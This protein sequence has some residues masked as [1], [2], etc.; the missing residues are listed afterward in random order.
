MRLILTTILLIVFTGCSNSQVLKTD[1]TGDVLK[2]LKILLPDNEV[3]VDIID[4]VKMDPRYELLYSKFLSAVKKNNEWFLQQQKT[5]EQTGNPMPY[6]PNVGMSESEY[7]EFKTLIEKGPG[8]EM[9]KSGSAKV[10]FDY[11]SDIIRL[12]GT[13]RLEILNDVKIDLENN[14]VW[15]GDFKL[16]DFQEINVDTDNNGLKSKWKGYQW[17]YEYTNKP[18]GFSELESP[19]DFQDLVMKQYKLTVGRLDKDLTTY[20]EITEKEIENGVKTKTIQ[21]PFKF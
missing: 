8:V 9:G 15:I 13:D 18:N 4:G 17:R 21:I 5:V 6:H 2:D 3:K 10:A 14:I 19:E 1:L 12:K 16:D 7:E 11:Q 20:I